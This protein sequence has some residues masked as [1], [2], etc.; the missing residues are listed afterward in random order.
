MPLCF[1][2]EVLVPALR[3]VVVGHWG[4]AGYL[5]PNSYSAR[6]VLCLDSLT[7]LDEGNLHQ[8][9]VESRLLLFGIQLPILASNRPLHVGLSWVPCFLSEA[10]DSQCC[11]RRV[12][13]DLTNSAIHS[14]LD[15][16]Q[17]SRNPESSLSCN[18]AV[19]YGGP[20]KAKHDEAPSGIRRC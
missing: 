13:N 15:Y 11:E 2:F 8:R 19:V 3:C 20:A 9:S 1:E 6:T 7:S 12:L 18:L 4:R 16:T 5:S 10:A 17:L 14:R